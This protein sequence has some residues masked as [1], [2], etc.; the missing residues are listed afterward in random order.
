[1]AKVNAD[2]AVCGAELLEKNLNLRYSIILNTFTRTIVCES[3]LYLQ[4]TVKK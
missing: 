1:M 4:K 2:R 3:F